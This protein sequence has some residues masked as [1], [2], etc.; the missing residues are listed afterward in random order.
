MKKLVWTLGLAALTALPAVGFAN[1]TTEL[2]ARLQAS[3]QRTVERTLVDGALLDLD[4]ST[5]QVEAFYPI[6]AHPMI[7]QFGEHY[8]LCSDLKRIDGSTATV[9]YYMTK[10]G[11]RFSVFRTEINNRGPLKSFMAEGKVTKLD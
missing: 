3:L 5:G 1:D 2:K 11:N 7:L 6:E 4:F 10:N 8:V 9:D